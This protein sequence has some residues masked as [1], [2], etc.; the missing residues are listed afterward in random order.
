MFDGMRGIGRVFCTETL[1]GESTHTKALPT[2]NQISPTLLPCWDKWGEV[3][4]SIWEG[5]EGGVGMR[6]GQMSTQT[7]PCL[8]QAGVGWWLTFEFARKWAW[9]GHHSIGNKKPI[10]VI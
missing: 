8:N 2:N 10:W 7:H 1:L 6:K 3:G 9:G 5:G 4:T